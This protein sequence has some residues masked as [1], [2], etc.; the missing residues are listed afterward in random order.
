MCANET[1]VKLQIASEWQLAAK[2]VYACSFI[3]DYIIR[4][5]LTNSLIL[6]FTMRVEYTLIAIIVIYNDRLMCLKIIIKG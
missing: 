3:Y 2:C 4:I 1:P 6:I 5:D